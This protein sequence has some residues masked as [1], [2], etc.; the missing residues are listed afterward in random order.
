MLK[1]LESKFGFVNLISAKRTDTLQVGELYVVRKKWIM[2]IFS[3]STFWNKR[4]STG[5]RKP[6]FAIDI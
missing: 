6:F 4:R 3:S 5:W 2:V 1:E